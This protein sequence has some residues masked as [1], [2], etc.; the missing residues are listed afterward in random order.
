M[1]KK[2][3]EYKDELRRKQKDDKFI[4]GTIESQYDN[5]LSVEEAADEL[6]KE[7]IEH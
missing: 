7:E 2:E 1:S 5:Y 3:Y 4:A 6:E